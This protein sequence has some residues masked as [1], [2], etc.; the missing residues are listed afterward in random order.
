MGV[1]AAQVRSKIEH[2]SNHQF[3]RR[4]VVAQFETNGPVRVDA[5]STDDCLPAG[6]RFLIAVR[7]VKADL[8]PADRQQNRQLAVAVD[9]DRLGPVEVEL[10]LSGVRAGVDNE[11]VFELPLFP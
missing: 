2:R 7:S 5:V 9:V 8:V 4:V 10:D 1:S 6:F 3:A 11:V